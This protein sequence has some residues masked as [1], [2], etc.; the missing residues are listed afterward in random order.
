MAY[1]VNVSLLKNILAAVGAVVVVVIFLMIFLSLIFG[2]GGLGVD[3]VAVVSLEG[4]ITDPTEI[5]RELKEYGER[6]DVKAVVLRIDSPGGAVGPSQEIHQEIKRLRETKPVVASLGAIAASGGYYAAA[7]ADK[8]VA[9]PGT[10]TGSIG[11]IIEFLNAEELLKKIGLR[12]YVL[13]SGKYKDTGSPFREMTNEER[14]LIQKVIDDVNTQFIIAVAE[15]RGLSEKDVRKIADGRI[16]T[17]SQA[18]ELGLVDTLGDLTDAIDI[19]AELAGLEEKPFVIYPRKRKLTFL[20]VIF[21][22][23]SARDIGEALSGFKIMYL[24][25]LPGS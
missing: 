13:K 6:E 17:G 5:A 21:G 10:I 24:L 19:G 15:G 1:P 7:G 9:N 3:K 23:G 4:V 2:G 25:R 14:M 20:D 18:R 11:V 16:F 8:I 12:G 22:E